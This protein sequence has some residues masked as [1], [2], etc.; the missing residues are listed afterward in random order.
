MSELKECRYNK[1][2]KVKAGRLLIH[3]TNCPDKNKSNLVRCN[4]DINHLVKKENL[5]SHLKSCPKKPNIDEKVHQEMLEYILKN[6]SKNKSTDATSQRNTIINPSTDDRNYDKN[7]KNIKFIA[8]LGPIEDKEEK[9]RQQREYR[10]LINNSNLFYDMSQIDKND[11]FDLIEIDNEFK[12]EVDESLFSEAINQFFKEDNIEDSV[13]ISQK[14]YDDASG[15]HPQEECNNNRN[16]KL[17]FHNSN[18]ENDEY[19][20]NSSDMYIGK[21]NKNNI[22]DDSEFVYYK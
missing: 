17:L 20:P 4:Y 8:G 10:H 2:H 6:A 18:L 1:N 11:E 16:I 7:K 3:E 5:Q 15:F 9:K 22:N 13:V 21:R 12:N 19:D 14:D